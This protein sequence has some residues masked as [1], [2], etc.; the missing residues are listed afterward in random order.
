MDRIVLRGHHLLCVHG[1][2]GMGYS[3]RFVEKMEEIVSR[4]RD[5]QLD[6]E[7]QVVAAIDDACHVCPNRQD[8][9]CMANIESNPHVL[10]MDQRVMKQLGIQHNDVYKKSD[11]L[12]LTVKKVDPEDLDYL[13]EG[14]S[15]LRYGVCKNG[16]KQLKKHDVE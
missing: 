16:L 10:S 9:I 15:W 1:F 4:I 5:R 3:L 13:C 11:L 8:E 14:C 7:I 6:F 2:Q 12:R